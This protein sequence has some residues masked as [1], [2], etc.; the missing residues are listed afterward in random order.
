MTKPRKLKMMNGIKFKILEWRQKMLLTTI[1]YS[2]WNNIGNKREWH[3]RRKEGMK[4]IRTINYM[5]NPKNMPKTTSKKQNNEFRN[6][7][8]MV[9]RNYNNT[10]THR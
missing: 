5:K 4:N 9:T 7:S 2:Q 6:Y 3:K 8:R 10:L 1:T